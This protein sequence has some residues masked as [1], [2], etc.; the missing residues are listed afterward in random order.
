MFPHILRFSLWT[1]S[2]STIRRLNVNIE[3]SRWRMKN[4][5]FE[6]IGNM[7]VEFRILLSSMN[8]RNYTEELNFRHCIIET[9]HNQFTRKLRKFSVQNLFKEK[10]FGKVQS[11]KMCKISQLN[12]TKSVRWWK[13]KVCD[14]ETR[15]QEFETTKNLQKLHCTTN[16]KKLL[17]C[18]YCGILEDF[19][20][21]L[22]HSG[23]CFFSSSSY[24]GKTL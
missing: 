9:C 18:C 12:C 3:H 17:V 1:S 11:V 22:E 6:L 23:S 10:L 4:E 8:N 15:R 19:F 14:L 7:K 21:V 16:R 2:N 20:S 5:N 24:K 13:W